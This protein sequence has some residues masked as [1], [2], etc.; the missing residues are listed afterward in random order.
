MLR[1]VG[2]GGG[3][4]LPVLLRGL[5]AC[6]AEPGWNSL[7]GGVNASAIVTVFDNGGSSG[8][9]RRAFGIPA[10][11]DLRNC[12]VAM[13]GDASVLQDIFQFRFSSGD[14]LQGH[15]LGN[16]IVAALYELSGD[17]KQ[18]IGLAGKLLR[19][20]GHVLP[21]TQAAVTLCAQY[22]NSQVQRGESQIALAD[23]R[24][25]SVWL[26]P[27]NPP[28]TP[29]VLQAIARAHALVLGPGSLYTS[30]VPNLLVAGVAEAI[31][32][33]PAV[34]IFVCNLMT[35]PG[36]TDRLTASD[37]LRALN[38]YLGPEAIDVC[39]VNGQPISETSLQKYREKG[40]EPVRLDPQQISRMGAT[41]VSAE[42]LADAESVISHDPTKLGRQILN[43]A[44]RDLRTQPEE[45]SLS[46]QL[47]GGHV[48]Q[49]SWAEAKP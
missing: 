25:R 19:L 18:A 16:L 4:G 41:P 22:E 45:I 29:G 46:V 23:V 14:G 36:Q 34:K 8:A 9:L 6:S 39:L 33:S 27:G 26:E 10:V 24:V 2:I 42:L 37:H 20:K 48:D 7:H 17:L 11:G 40:S 38:N 13:S 15:A 5:K 28:P 43:L 49:G 44:T 21:V 32:N 12:L 3:T 35:E 31:R 47:P 1:I 30:I